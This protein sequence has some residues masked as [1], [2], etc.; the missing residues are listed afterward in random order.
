[1]FLIP[2][3]FDLIA[4]IAQQFLHPTAAALQAVTTHHALS[5]TVRPIYPLSPATQCIKA[6]RTNITSQPFPRSN[7]CSRS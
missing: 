7:I 2:Q 1:M 4:D 6:L 5:K 3:W